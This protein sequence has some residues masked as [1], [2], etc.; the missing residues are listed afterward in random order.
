[1]N[2]QN[3][4]PNLLSPS[5]YTHRLDRIEEKIDR[6]ADAMISIARAEER[7]VAIEADRQDYWNRMNSHSEKI[8]AHD[9]QI[10][11]LNMT[12][13]KTTSVLEVVDKHAATDKE[14]MW[15]SFK[16]QGQRVGDLEKQLSDMKK[17]TSLI[18]KVT[19]MIA[20][21]ATMLV[22]NQFIQFLPS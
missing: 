17:T 9:D 7:I 18:N 4:S 12:L 21:T 6:L 14:N 1:M 11:E 15:N 2:D 3:S 20:A 5:H 13:S 16:E 8:D 10:A 22:M 19:W